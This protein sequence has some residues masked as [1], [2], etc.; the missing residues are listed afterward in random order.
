[1][2]SDLMLIR[3]WMGLNPQGLTAE[4]VLEEFNRPWGGHYYGKAGF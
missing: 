1:M 4:R 2:T 3:S